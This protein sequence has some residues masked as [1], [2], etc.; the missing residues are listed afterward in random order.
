MLPCPAWSEVEINQFW[1]SQWLHREALS[2]KNKNNKQKM[3]EINSWP[4]KYWVATQ[5]STRELMGVVSFLL[6]VGFASLPPLKN[7][8]FY[9]VITLVSC[10]TAQ[11]I[12][13]WPLQAL[14]LSGFD[15]G[16]RKPLLT[17]HYTEAFFGPNPSF[18]KPSSILQSL[19]WHHHT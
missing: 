6:L 11:R 9:F 1:D 7:K 16:I 8:I 10:C 2:Y 17:H 18:P 15:T 3:V 14:R 5:L 19:P 4:E 12:P 13:V